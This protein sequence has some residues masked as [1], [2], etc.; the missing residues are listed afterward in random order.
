M[1]ECPMCGKEVKL[2]KKDRALRR[3]VKWAAKMFRGLREITE[4]AEPYCNDCWKEA[5][6]P[7]AKGIHSTL[8]GR[9][10]DGLDHDETA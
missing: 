2:T 5:V 8:L 9:V 3:Q 6:L 7:A 10:K 1:T 4:M